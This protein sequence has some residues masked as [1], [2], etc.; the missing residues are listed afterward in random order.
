M[1]TLSIP[2]SSSA[3]LAVEVKRLKSALG[4]AEHAAAMA[5]RTAEDE[6]VAEIRA[7]LIDKQCELD[8]AAA[9]EA[10]IADQ[11]RVAQDLETLHA[12]ENDQRETHSLLVALRAESVNLAQRLVL[13]EHR[14]NELLRIRGEL[15]KKFGM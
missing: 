1:T 9:A 8:T 2:S 7:Q 4:D 14:H 13:T 15:K 11:D 6:K 3:D 12:I 10:T 5:R